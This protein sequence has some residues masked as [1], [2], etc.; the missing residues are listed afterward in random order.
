M[1]FFSTGFFILN[2]WLIL[3][4]PN[5][6]CRQARDNV[7]IGARQAAMAETFV[8]IADDG[9]AI[10]W[11]PAGLPALRKY[12]INVAYANLFGLDLQNTYVSLFAPIT[13]R[14]VLG[15]DWFR[16]GFNDIED[17]LG[18]DFSQ[19][20]F[21]FSAA[22]KLSDFFSLGGNIKVVDMS[23]SEDNVSVG[24]ASGTGYD[25]GLL[26]SPDDRFGALL[27]KLRF[28]IMFH[29]LTNTG[30]R[31]DN[32]ATDTIFKR[33]IRYGAAFKPVNNLTL[34]VDFDDRIHFG[35]EFLLFNTLAL[36]GGVQKDLHTSEGAM[37]S[38]G[39]GV[40]QK[41][42][43]F[44]RV[45]ANYAF[46]DNSTRLNT[47]Q[48]SAGI[49]FDL[50]PDLI[51]IVGVEI[52]D[53]YAS[54][55]KYHSKHPIGKVYVKFNG[56]QELEC[57]IEGS[58]FKYADRGYIYKKVLAQRD[59]LY[60]LPVRAVFA[61]STL[62][63][64]ETTPLVAY[65]SVSYSSG[66]RPKREQ[67]PGGLFRLYKRGVIDWAKGNEQAAAFIDPADTTIHAFALAIAR[68]IAG[69]SEP[70]FAIPD[71]QNFSVA[72]HIFN[73]LAEMGVSYR[74][75]PDSPYSLHAQGIDL[76][77]Y[78]LETLMRKKG[79]CDD[80]SVLLAALLENRGIPTALVAL[81]GHLL[82]MFDSGIPENDRSK[83]FPI[84]DWY[85]PWRGSYW[86]PVETT[87]LN[88]HSFVQAWRVGREK[89]RTQK[90]EEIV[91]VREAWQTYEP[92]S[93]PVEGMRGQMTSKGQNG[94]DPAQDVAALKALAEA[95]LKK[96]EQQVASNPND[97]ALRKQLALKY[98]R[99]PWRGEKLA[100]ANTQYREILIRTSDPVDRVA[101]YNDMANIA[102]LREKANLALADSLYLRAFGIASR[103][104][105]ADTTGIYLN[106]GTLFLAIG[107]DSTAATLYALAVEDSSK[108]GLAEHYLGFDFGAVEDSAR[109]A[110]G[111]KKK[112]RVTK[113]RVKSGVGR[114][115]KISKSKRKRGEQVRLASRK[116]TEISGW[117]IEDVF[118]WAIGAE[119]IKQE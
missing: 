100:L 27:E 60:E 92:A 36:R 108:L 41:A 21:H 4:A 97:L 52:D 113:R 78:P 94:Q 29:D 19:N 95:E 38:F 50:F 82:M 110:P 51:E 33:N 28:G 73:A 76:I 118:F 46:S 85:Y 84:E 111:N 13:R 17:G 16:L 39:V 48:F 69:A 55:Y 1:K 12:E 23:G 43:G 77:Y 67:A 87:L 40:S 93:P 106:R 64:S 90:V 58:I 61:P 70:F 68:Q 8:A 37:F 109:A 34:G 11:N 47:S 99:W 71:H 116:T 6:F 88:Q 44:D 72:L 32:G 26:F 91:S 53:L 59:S 3:S 25:L 102:L 86:V 79:D 101:A 14:F 49:A 81:P 105:S 15:A 89:L 66:D 96:L 30:V 75:D 63:V 18:L 65:L 103:I 104:A 35:G 56:K 9:T 115:A 119:R 57:A 45:R 20:V 42:P 10:Y 117:E 114:G 107:Q 5:G 112:K 54:Q 74:E 24:K 98:A 80:T 62:Q 7:F 2:F 22:F 31:F 83:L